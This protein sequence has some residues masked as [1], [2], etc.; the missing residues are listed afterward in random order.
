MAHD[1]SDG[2]G[3]VLTKGRRAEAVVAAI[4]ELNEHTEVI[5]RGTY[6]RVMVPHCCTVTR[7]AIEKHA[8][9][10]FLLPWR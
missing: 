7:L 10:P 5:D 3:P 1:A 4:R 2:V 8:G 6:L 9:E